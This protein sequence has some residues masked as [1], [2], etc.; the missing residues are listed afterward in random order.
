MRCARS[1]GQMHPEKKAQNIE[2]FAVQENAPKCTN[3]KGSQPANAIIVSNAYL[4]SGCTK[5]TYKDLVINQGGSPFTISKKQWS[6]NLASKDNAYSKAELQIVLPRG[7]YMKI[8]RVVLDNTGMFAVFKADQGSITLSHDDISRL[9]IEC[10][11]LNYIQIEFAPNVDNAYTYPARYMDL[12]QANMLF[13]G[14]KPI[15][16]KGVAFGNTVKGKSTIKGTSSGFV[17]IPIMSTDCLRYSVK[18]SVPKGQPH[19]FGL[20]IQQGVPLRTSPIVYYFAIPVTD[21]NVGNPGFILQLDKNVALRPSYRLQL[22]KKKPNVMNYGYVMTITKEK[23]Q[24]NYI[25][26]SPDVQD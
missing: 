20:V 2:T 5:A 24:N 12:T 13:P 22:L 1:K 23:L 25:C 16:V 9:F 26:I 14:F 11:N 3:G 10:E 17:A 21:E 15:K 8:T 4:F 6:K 19:D 18:T 7:G